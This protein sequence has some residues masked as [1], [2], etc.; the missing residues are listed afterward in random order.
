MSFAG[1]LIIIVGVFVRALGINRLPK[2]TFLLFWETAALR[3]LV[4]FSVP[5]MFSIFS[6]S[7]KGGVK[8]R[9]IALEIIPAAES[10]ENMTVDIPLIYVIWAAGVLISG[11][12]FYT[13][14]FEMLSR[15]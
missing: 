2:K 6:V 1:A 3:L 14:V 5:F 7:E 9:S 4:P 10:A 12:C 13:D 8:N 15:I 11:S